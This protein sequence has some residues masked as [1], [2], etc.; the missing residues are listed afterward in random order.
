MT[1]FVTER[2]IFVTKRTI[3][4][5][6]RT[7][8]FPKKDDIYLLALVDRQGSVA[9]LPLPPDLPDDGAAAHSQVGQLLPVQSP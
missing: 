4:V 6:K 3:F 1:I 9:L 7:P 5:T 8:F 2:T